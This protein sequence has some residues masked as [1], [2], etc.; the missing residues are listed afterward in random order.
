MQARKDITYRWAINHALAEEMRLD[1]M[2]VLWGE[3]IGIHGGN[4]GVTRG[5]VE[6]FGEERVRDTPIS[7]IAIVGTS[8][9]AA[10]TGLRP[11]VEIM[12]AGF[13]GC[14]FD[15]LFMKLGTWRQVHGN[16]PVPVVVR[17]PMGGAGG[18]GL[19]HAYC[20]E[21]LLIHSPGLK[22]LVPSTPYDAKGLLKT[23]IRGEDP[24]VYLEHI[25]LYTKRGP[26][27]D[28]DTL[29]PFG[30]AEVRREGKDATIV[31]Y[32]AMVYKAM[33]AAERLAQEGIEC[34]VIDLRTR[35]RGVWWWC[36]RT[37]SAAGSQARSWQ[38]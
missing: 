28:A 12:F 21:A 3:D 22:V 33:E 26:V 6:E 35:R 9:G 31:T 24:C 10:M 2:V 38:R 1:P 14:C 27:G 8:V 29:V 16:I 19:E 4:F 34:E 11:V 13:I 7:E 20:P 5:L 15:A 23:A 30:K 36:T 18:A 32:S 37:W 25:A 17:A